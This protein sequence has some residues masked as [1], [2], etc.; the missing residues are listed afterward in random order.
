MES[1]LASMTREGV[2]HFI[3]FSQN[4]ESKEQL[5]DLNDRIQSVV[6]TY[7]KTP[8]LVS[9][10]QE[11][12]RV[13]RF[14][15][16]FTL[17]PTARKVGEKNSPQLAYEVTRIQAR[18]L[19]AAGLQLNFA[20][21]CDIH[22]NPDNPVI[23]D[24]AYG[25][26][27]DDVGRMA[28]AVVRGHLNEGVEACLKHFPGHG[29]THVDS[30]ESLPRVDTP[31]DI[32]RSREWIPFH[33]AMRSGARFVMSAHIL[34]PHLDATCPGTLSPTF[35]KNHLRGELGYSGVI[36]SDDMEMGAIT[37]N[38]SPEEAPLLALRAGCDLLC[39][40]SESQ[41]LIAIEAI[42]R[43]LS[44]GLLD[45]EDIRRSIDRT[46]KIRASLKLAKDTLP[47]EKRLEVI[48]HPEHQE[49]ILKNF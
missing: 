19:F 16:G 8:A 32:L 33:K 31:L 42:K 30:H 41:A 9:V 43:A 29:D 36:V 12:G 1:T 26:T 37:R 34:L 4:Y 11:G 38:Y 48:G 22:T 45:W 49:F 6:S 10:D 21:V 24:R 20:P 44:D 3:L 15:A 47:I 25:S 18:E 40:R 7:S 35:L 5:I 27:A 14:R 46:R 17:L 23:G 28:S 39:Y 13:Q 2:S